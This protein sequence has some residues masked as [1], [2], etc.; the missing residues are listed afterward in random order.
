MMRGKGTAKPGDEPNLEM[1]LERVVMESFW[2]PFAAGRVFPWPAGGPA[3]R[4]GSAPAGPWSTIQARILSMKASCVP[5]GGRRERFGVEVCRGLLGKHLRRR[6]RPE[7]RTH[8][9]PA[10]ELKETAHGSLGG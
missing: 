2:T 7:E 1:F 5:R 4:R 3:C 6:F 9:P 10:T 8:G